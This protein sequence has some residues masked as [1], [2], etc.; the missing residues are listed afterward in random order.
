[1][2]RLKFDASVVKPDKDR[3]I[4]PADALMSIFGFT[5]AKDPDLAAYVALR[6]GAGMCHRCGRAPSK[7]AGCPESCPCEHCH[8][9][10]CKGEC[11][12]VATMD[13]AVRGKR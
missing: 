12:A 5:R 4:G 10:K 1:M 2:K 13:A 6:V 8:G 11:V 9:R 7:S 3:Y